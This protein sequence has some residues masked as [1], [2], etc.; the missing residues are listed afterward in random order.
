M[1]EQDHPTSYWDSVFEEEKPKIIESAKTGK[2]PLDNAL[3]WLIEGSDSVLDFG[4]GNGTLLGYLAKR[5]KAQYYGIDQSINAVCSARKL[6]RINEL[7]EGVFERGSVE[8]LESIE[9]NAFS[10]AVLSNIL[11]N[12][13]PKEA[14]KVIHEMHRII[15]PGGK[16]LIKLNDYL[17]QE[18]IK[19]YAMQPVEQDFYLESN[20]LYFWNKPTIYWEELF[21][22]VFDIYQQLTIT[23]EEHE[24]ENRLFLLINKA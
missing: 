22:G 4:C 21:E 24:V 14:I 15:E 19:Q 3:D 12:L 17:K 2:E 11:D 10:A 16:L 20:G 13:T 18:L 5:K 7:S 1:K 8:R 6:F 23:Y 9:T